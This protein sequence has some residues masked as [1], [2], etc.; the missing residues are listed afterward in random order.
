VALD[1][2][3]QIE[4]RIFNPFAYRGA[5]KLMRFLEFTFSN[6]RLDYRMHN[7]LMV[8]DNAVALIG[9][10]NVGDEYFQIDPDGQAADDDVFAAGPIVRELS[11]TFDEFWRSDL[12]IPV[13]ALAGGTASDA[14]LAAY[15]QVL[16]E[17]RQQLKEDGTD[18]ASR[19]ATGEPLAG[20]LSGRLPLVWAHAQLVYDSPEKKRV[21]KGQMVGRL[22]HRPVADAAAAVQS[23]L[24]M[25]TPY[26]IPGAEGMKIFSDLR[27]RG[28]R[29][30]ILTN[31]LES[32]TVLIAQAGYMNYRQ[33]LLEQ[34]VE[35][36]EVR[37]L[38]GNSRGSG[39][40]EKI[41][42]HG[43]YSLHAK[44][45]IFDRRSLFIGSMNFDQR[46]AH[47]NTEI[48]LI[49]D[50]PELARQTA[51]RFAAMVSPPNCY[52]LALTARDAGSS[53]R[54]VWRTEE[55]GKAVEYD[56]EPARSDGQRTQVWLLSLLPVDDEL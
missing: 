19:V 49:I 10:R 50:S 46:S 3:P 38:L 9:G 36:R 8:V 25:V 12:T 51:L 52:S 27:K 14:A 18:F 44:L 35:L 2:H 40:T 56:V 39:Q 53:T 47:L 33:P 26:L 7:K 22:M 20:L 37:A 6:A 11:R 54:L 29:V 1:A 24:L 23:E 15:R 42:R 41:S 17:H 43:H 55:G 32:A 4:V 16:T 21:D 34:G 45:F 31:S 30:S 28:V 48:G 5:S 13:L